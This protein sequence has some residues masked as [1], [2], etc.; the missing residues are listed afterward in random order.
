ME[1]PGGKDRIFLDGIYA[2]VSICRGELS[3]IRLDARGRSS[4]GTRNSDAQ[5]S[6]AADLVSK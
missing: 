3:S 4:G 1:K 6:A 2:E 5:T